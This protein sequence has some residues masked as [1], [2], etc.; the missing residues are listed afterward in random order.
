[1]YLAVQCIGG[2][3][4]RVREKFADN[5]KSIGENIHITLHIFEREVLRV[6]ADGQKR[7]IKE[8]ILPGYLIAEVIQGTF[9]EAYHILKNTDNVINVLREVSQS[10]IKHIRNQIEDRKVQIVEPYIVNDRQEKLVRKIKKAIFIG[11]QQGVDKKI[12][13]RLRER[14]DLIREQRQRYFQ[15]LRNFN[16]IKSFRQIKGKRAV[17]EFP[18]ELLQVLEVRDNLIQHTGGRGDPVALAV[19]L[20]QATLTG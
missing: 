4:N 15:Y 8:N 9:E 2:R 18:L 13:N 14:M 3:E 10:E 1:M 19:R 12:V 7:M 20:A 11:E 5:K 16:L 6:S 17:Y